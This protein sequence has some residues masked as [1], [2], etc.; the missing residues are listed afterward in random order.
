MGAEWQSVDD[1]LASTSDVLFPERMGRQRVTVGS[2]APD[3]DTPLH[4]IVWRNDL[5]A[6]QL[7]LRAGADVNAQGDMGY[8]PLHV[9]VSEGNVAMV[10]V[11]L[12]AGARADLMAEIAGTARDEAT[13]KGGPMAEV[14][15][16]RDA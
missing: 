10:K 4:V 12:E 16:K 14:F 7:L 1:V 8:T 2:R 13:R 11:L 9:A 5:Q 15:A 3:G 6:A